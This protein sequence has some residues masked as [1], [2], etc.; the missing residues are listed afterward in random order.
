M[1]R[2]KASKLLWDEVAGK[3]ENRPVVCTH[4]GNKKAVNDGIKEG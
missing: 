3:I 1:T 2:K 4:N